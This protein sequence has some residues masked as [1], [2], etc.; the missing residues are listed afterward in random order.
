MYFV[1]LSPP[2]YSEVKCLRVGNWHIWSQRCL[3][4]KDMSSIPR[5]FE[6]DQNI[7]KVGIQS[8]SLTFSKR[9]SQFGDETLK[10]ACSVLG[11]DT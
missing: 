7:E 6:S 1:K 8:F 5:L 4:A 10:F 3:V 11:Q 2:A 9:Y